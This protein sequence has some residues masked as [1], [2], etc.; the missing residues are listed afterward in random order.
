[1]SKVIKFQNKIKEKEQSQNTKIMYKL[2]RLPKIRKLRGTYSSGIIIDLKLDSDEILDISRLE[3][4]H[5][6]Y[7]QM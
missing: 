7:L 6:K 4:C 3:P 1:M 5:I 2:Q